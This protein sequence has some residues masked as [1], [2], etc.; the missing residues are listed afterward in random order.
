MPD[1]T[2]TAARL[3]TRTDPGGALTLA[4]AGRLD[5]HALPTLWPDATAAVQAHP[6]DVVIDGSGLDYCDGAGLG[7]FAELRRL[8]HARGGQ[9][10]FAGF[11]PDL[12][13]LVRS[14]T[15]RDPAAA[16]LTPPRH[17]NWVTQVGRST[18][19]ILDD[20]AAIIRFVGEMTLALAWAL[21]HPRKVRWRDALVVAQRVGADAVPVVCLLGFLIG[22]IIAFQSAAP[23]RRFG[24]DSLIPTLVSVAMIRELGPLI[25]AIILAGRS[26]SAFAAEIGTMKVTEELN[27]L[28]TFGLDPTRFLVIPRVLAAMLVVPLLSLFATVMGIVGGYLVQASL[29]YSLSFYLNAVSTSATPTD[30]IQGLAKMVVFAL[31]VAGV[32]CLR[33]LRTASGPGAVG[34]STTKAVVA[35]IVLVVAADGII[36]VVLYFL[37]I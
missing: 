29:G 24:A 10:T 9:L 20:I 31:L 33:G 16:S 12:E 3:D 28:E 22:L 11:N 23:M 27:A 19:L 7:L 2:T 30:L 21:C 13:A 25:T 35:G 8:A 4:L 15:L 1:D 36:G 5:R 34:D 6:G 18:A 17:P 26:G 37:G 14:A 32:G